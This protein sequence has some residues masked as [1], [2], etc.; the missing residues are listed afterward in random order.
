MSYMNFIMNKIKKEYFQKIFSTCLCNNNYSTIIFCATFCLDEIKDIVEEL[1]DEFHIK[2][3][4]FNDFDKNKIQTFFNKMPSEKE[5]EEFIPKFP[6]PVGNIKIIY[7][8]NPATD[9]S[10]AP[11]VTIVRNTIIT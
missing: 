7:F 9:L 5:I 10:D 1:K 8:D 6:S 3:I 11:T 4:I 2:R